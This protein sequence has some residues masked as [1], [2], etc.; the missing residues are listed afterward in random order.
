MAVAIL[1]FCWFI[2]L[3]MFVV[4]VTNRYAKNNY[5]KK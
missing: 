3:R 1:V 5:N 4:G 2:F